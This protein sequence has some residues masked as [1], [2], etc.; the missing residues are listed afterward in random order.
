MV[1][2][3]VGRAEITD[4]LARERLALFARRALHALQSR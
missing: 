1:Y 2:R 4:E 3:E